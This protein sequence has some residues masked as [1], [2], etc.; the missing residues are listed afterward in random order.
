MRAA[1]AVAGCGGDEEVGVGDG[2][3]GVEGLGW[4]ADAQSGGVC[5]FV[6]MLCLVNALLRVEKW[7]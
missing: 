1:V 4:G 5:E 7:Y 6:P 3:E 2:E